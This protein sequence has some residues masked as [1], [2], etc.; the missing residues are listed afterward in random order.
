MRFVALLLLLCSMTFSRAETLKIAILSYAPPFSVVADNNHFFGFDVELMDAVCKKIQ[1]ECQY[2]PVGYAKLLTMVKEQKAD[3]GIG[4]I[5][6]TP[7]IQYQFLVSLPYLTSD[8]QL[9]TTL[10]S[11]VNSEADLRGKRIGT[12][13]NALFTSMVEKKYREVAKIK[14]YTELPE[15]LQ[16]L[17]EKEVDVVLIHEQV[18]KFWCAG[19]ELKAQFKLIGEKISLGSGY[20]IIAPHGRQALIDRINQALIQLETDG[21]YVKLYKDYFD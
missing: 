20:G 14:Q 17:A 3:L 15:L 6:I 7:D 8:G 5:S 13:S 12:W 11:P 10:K 2:I 4:A 19:E 1:A 9:M 18:A 16:A 21:T